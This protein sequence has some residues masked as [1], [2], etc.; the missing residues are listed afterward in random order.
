MSKQDKNCQIPTPVKYVEQMLDYVGYKYNLRGHKVL[1]NSC[2]E[3]NILIEIVKRYI[4]DARKNNNTPEE[5][6]E[7]L[8]KDIIAYEI[9]RVKIDICLTRLNDLVSDERLPEVTWN[10]KHQDFLKSKENN[11]EFIIGNPP[12]ITYHD[13]TQKE[14]DILQKKYVVC[15]Q[16]RFDYCYAFIEAS[17]KALAH[18]GKM[19]YLIPFSIFRNR[20]ANGV[21]GFIRDYITKIIDYRSI[22]V[23][24]GIT[25]STSL[26]LC[27]K[28]NVPNCIG[29]EDVF[30]HKSYNIQ[31]STLSK[32]GEKWIFQNNNGGSKR[33]GDYFHVHNSVATLCNKAFLF[34]VEKEDEQYYFIKDIPVE[35]EVTLPAV[36]TKSI[37]TLKKGNCE[38]RIIF[39]YK[40]IN[41]KIA[42]YMEA[43]FKKLYPCTCEYLHQFDEDLDKRNADKKAKWFEYGRSQALTEIFGEKLIIPMVITETTGICIADQDSIPYAGYF[44][45]MNNNCNMTLQDAKKLLESPHFYQY[46]KDVGTPTTLSSYR[47]SVHDISEYRF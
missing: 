33:F 10:I 4:I 31:R 3:G 37:R 39:P 14:R 17:L 23:F 41:G 40:R 1:E 45:T 5:I 36:S 9:D 16:G 2:G 13:L 6:V 30:S 43:E 22:N 11:I 46:V 28:Q 47:V 7:G 19:I 21:R 27:E 12:Y 32:N 29:Y 25:C 20:Y 18:N 8:E 24:P 44:I 34:S 26:I 15:K 35:K 38:T 42:H